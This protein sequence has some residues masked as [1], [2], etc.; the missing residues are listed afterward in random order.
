M[1]DRGVIKHGYIAGKS[2]KWMDI[3]SWENQLP[4]RN[5]PA[6]HVWW[7]QGRY[8]K[9]FDAQQQKPG[10]SRDGDEDGDVWYKK[11]E[12]EQDKVGIWREAEA[13]E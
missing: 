2:L 9:K 13:R 5:Y 11:S 6:S 4:M 7:P 1:G 10:W 8:E 3:Y 12:Y